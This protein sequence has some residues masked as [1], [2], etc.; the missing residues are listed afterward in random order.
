M[1]QQ[2]LLLFMTSIICVSNAFG[3]FQRYKNHRE[4]KDQLEKLN[5]TLVNIQKNC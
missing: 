3:G 2:K 5:K 1:V 4:I